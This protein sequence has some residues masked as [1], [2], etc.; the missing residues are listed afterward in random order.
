MGLAVK[1]LEYPITPERLI[2]SLL[3]LS[4]GRQVSILDSCGAPHLDSRWLIAAIDPVAV[5][6]IQAVS[7]PETLRLLDRVAA[8]GE[9]F[10]VMTFAY[11]FG[12]KMLDIGEARANVDAGPE[13]DVFL[14]LYEAVVVFDYRT[15]SC[16][17]AGRES[18]FEKIETA[19]R[20]A[21]AFE[22]SASQDSIAIESDFSRREYLTAIEQVKERIRRGD[23]YQTNLTQQLRARLP[24]TL[25]PQT[26]FYRLRRDHP[27]PFAA[28]IRRG[29]STVVSASPERFFQ[30]K[31]KNNR[32]SGA[33]VS[34][35]P[36]KGTRPRGRTAADDERL[37]RELKTSVKDRAENVMI[38]DLLR[39]DLGRVCRYGS[40]GVEK[41]CELATHSTLHH[42]VST[43]SGT[44]AEN[45]T[46]AELLAAVFPC[47]SITG[48]PKISTMQIIEEIERSPRGLSM[49]AIGYYAPCFDPPATLESPQRTNSHTLLDFSVAIRTIVVRGREAVF[50][51][52]GGIVIDSDPADEYEE[53]LVK[54][55]AILSAIGGK[56]TS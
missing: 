10:A 56:I 29:D 45:V 2:E 15:Q 23:T 34:T 53:S 36:I 27:A 52:G 19:L 55:R 28:F 11:E 50:N 54:A 43:V 31:S 39:N 24:E 7:V 25:T 26:I 30:V 18:R 40:V 38:V 20:T 1:T 12:A 44:L 5:Q 13:P 35:S 41:L 16:F 47:G 14:A 42:L 4:A 32:L 37:L 6:E 3:V 17:L 8:Q 51:V 9:H 33:V 22:N 46:F 48:A 21:G 49:G